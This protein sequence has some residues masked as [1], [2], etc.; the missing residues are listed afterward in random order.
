MAAKKQRDKYLLPTLVMEPGKLRLNLDLHSRISDFLVLDPNALQKDQWIRLVESGLQSVAV[1][2]EATA[3]I[4]TV[5]QLRRTLLATDD[6]TTAPVPMP[7]GVDPQWWREQQA[8]RL[9]GAHYAIARGLR[10]AVRLSATATTQA[11]K[12]KEALHGS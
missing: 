4:S 6:V 11:K 9:D 3:L 1:H 8:E 10:E 12:L 2:D 5:E 7:R